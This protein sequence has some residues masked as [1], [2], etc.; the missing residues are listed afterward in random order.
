MGRVS[1]LV[2]VAVAL[3][4]L[5]VFGG[6]TCIPTET[7]PPQAAFIADVREGEAPLR[8]QFTDYSTQGTASIR[9]W[10]WSFGDAGTSAAKNPTYT[11][12]T[13]GTFAVSL[14]VTTDDG[15]DT[16]T[17][18]GYITVIEPG[19][20]LEEIVVTFPRDGATVLVPEDVNNVPL[21]LLAETNAPQDTVSVDFTLDSVLLGSVSAPPYALTY[22]DVTT[23]SAAGHDIAV[24]AGS[25]HDPATVVNA[26]AVFT[27]IR[28]ATTED[29]YENGIPDNPFATLAEENSLWLT[30][31]DVPETRSRRYVAATAWSGAAAVS[32]DDVVT[33][34]ADPTDTDQRI[35]VTASRALLEPGEQGVLLVQV[36]SDLATWFGPDALPL[37]GRSP[38]GSRVAG[39][40]YVAVC[41]IVSADGGETYDVLDSTRLAQYPIRVRYDGLTRTADAT[42][43]FYSHAL[44]VQGD[45]TTGVCVQPVAGFWCDRHLASGVTGPTFAETYL[46]AS[47][48]LTLYEEV[49]GEADHL[50]DDFEDAT[51]NPGLWDGGANP[52]L[53][54]GGYLDFSVSGNTRLLSSRAGGY[55][56]IE[57][58]FRLASAAGATYGRLAAQWFASTDGALVPTLGIRTDDSGTATIRAEV[59][60]TSTQT[61]QW[62]RG[63]ELSALNTDVSLRMGFDGAAGL[64]EF[65]RDDTLFASYPASGEAELGSDRFGLFTLESG[66]A[67]GAQAAYFID[68]VYVWRYYAA[69]HP[70]PETVY[71]SGQASAPW[72]GTE[73]HPFRQIADAFPLVLDGGTIRVLASTY[74]EHVRLDGQVGLPALTDVSL[75]GETDVVI[76]GGGSGTGIEVSALDAVTVDQLEI[77]NCGVALSV[78]A[79]AGVTSIRNVSVSGSAGVGME[80]AAG[81][82]TVTD[83][84][85]S[86]NGDKGIRLH[87]ISGAPIV[88]E[89]CYVQNNL[90]CGVYATGLA[91]SLRD[92]IIAGNEARPADLGAGVMAG[93][94]CAIENNTIADNLNGAGMVLAVPAGSRVSVYNNIVA[95]NETAGIDASQ[96]F[97]VLEI[98]HNDVWGN[99]GGDYISVGA[100]GAHAVSLDPVFAAV[101]DYHLARESQCINAGSNTFAQAP[102]QLDIDGEARIQM[103][104]V[105]IG[106]DET[107]WDPLQIVDFP[108]SALK[109]AVR[110]AINKPAGDI[111]SSDLAG[112]G[113]TVLRANHAG[114]SD[115]T[116]LEYCTDLI[117]LELDGNTIQQITQL[118]P[119]TGLR[120]LR[121]GDN[122]I[123]DLT[124]LAGLTQ[125]TWLELFNNRIADITALAAMVNLRELQL[126]DNQIED[127]TALTD[128]QLLNSLELE[129]NQIEDV[130]ALVD[131]PG[132]GSSLAGADFVDLRGDPLGQEALCTDIPALLNRGADVRY[133]G[134]CAAEGEGEGEGRVLAWGCNLQG[135]L[136]VNSTISS[137]DP[138]AVTELSNAIDCDAGDKHSLA[139]RGDGAVWAWG[140]NSSGQLGDG[141]T[142]RRLVPVQ[143]PGLTGAVHVAAGSAHSLA[144]K[145]TG[146]VWAWGANGSGRLGDG[147]TATR[148]SPVEVEGL[149]GAIA[150]AAGSAHSIALRND[151]TVWAWGSNE[152]GQLGDNTAVNRFSPAPVEILAGV[153]AIAAGDNHSL[154]VR[155]DGTVWA[156]GMNT[157]GQLG[158]DSLIN[159]YQ[160]IQT[161][162][163]AGAVQAAAGAAHSLARTST[164]VV[165]AWGSNSSGQLGDSTTIR[166]DAPVQVENLMGVA[167]IAAGAA[168][169]LAAR[170]DGTAWT[171]GHNGLGQLGDGTTMR[172]TTPVQITD[173]TG[174]V[175][176]AG[177]DLHSLAIT[178]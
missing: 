8:V 4:G 108:D 125:L 127:L 50:Y 11:Y 52:P 114:V 173:L 96:V 122:Q 115:L 130:Q 66:A 136:G 150:I 106:A 175:R 36:A 30:A 110:S 91:F 171:W 74:L 93:T 57:A 113:F 152:Y 119:L 177:G 118:A 87:A 148:T 176:M 26:A 33:A 164:G 168:H 89:R 60:D 3:A 72:L 7:E 23:L 128:M 98:D 31:F 86:G 88:I 163:V 167:H 64:I 12:Q 78:E 43:F 84:T 169:S 76:D 70:V 5:V 161:H 42:A 62:Y 112:A 17:K 9:S 120:V 65:F 47:S 147:T 81:N 73:A 129:N 145:G 38:E 69:Q 162:T 25:V 149:T 99:A 56:A 97:G 154:A 159:R 155:S 142:A 151:G 39:A 140:D 67:Q 101:D 92:S 82:T 18:A 63:V 138:M 160:P 49:G 94:A 131:N 135:Q 75:V 158:D 121:L 143:V 16:E 137:T 116:G 83:C 103:G 178:E 68:N 170:G 32:T 109:A 14:T 41:L 40:P 144:L 90:G 165:W 139:V 19:S 2:S 124:P 29:L 71:V 61:A 105:D 27:L 102:A 58:T 111:Y 45:E 133:D 126:G 95:G 141:T 21:A 24:A 6:A 85:V 22:A 51:L 174:I 55:R 59:T 166:R 13:A 123:A 134:E 157:D 44:A 35:T 28:A 104:T 146:T 48:A 80:V 107:S 156:W 77:R 54:N 20:L 46:L 172:K 117:T 79:S 100:P 10:A 1:V 53:E 153:V 15:T 132:I 37:L 34:L